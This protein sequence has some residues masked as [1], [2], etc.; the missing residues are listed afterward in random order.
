MVSAVVLPH[1]ADA[2]LPLPRTIALSVPAIP[3]VHALFHVRAR[4]DDTEL[5][6]DLLHDR[7]LH[8]E[9][10]AAGEKAQLGTRQDG[11]A[12]VIA[13]IAVM[14]IGHEADRAIVE[15]D[16]DARWL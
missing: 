4:P 16:P 9:G 8:P 6:R 14:M 11:E 1:P 15:D 5:A 7:D 13:I 3:T 10:V 2:H 12:R